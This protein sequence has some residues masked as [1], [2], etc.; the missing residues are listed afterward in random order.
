MRRS[1]PRRS[2]FLGP[3]RLHRFEILAHGGAL[4]LRRYA[5]VGEF[6][7]VPTES[8][9]EVHPAAGEVIEA[10]DGLGERDGVVLEG[11]CDGGAQFDRRRHRG[12]EP[13]RH[14]RIEGA[15][16]TVVGK[17]LV[18]RSRMRGFA[19]DRD[20]G[21]FGHVET[22]ETATL[23]GRGSDFGPDSPVAREQGDSVA[24]NSPSPDGDGENVTRSTSGGKRFPDTCPVAAGRPY[25]KAVVPR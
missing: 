12:C 13:Q 7:C 1:L 25:E 2:F 20:V 23:R 15:H 8:D 24:H 9:T 16:V 3:Q 11:Q 21:V 17:G 14:P 5:V 4:L 6:F 18:A 22:V 19:A 10:R